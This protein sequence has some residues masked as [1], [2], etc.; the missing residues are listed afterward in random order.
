MESAFE[1]D[2]DTLSQSSVINSQLQENICGSLPKKNE[3][4]A[5]KKPLAATAQSAITCALSLLS[6][7]GTF[8]A[9]WKFAEPTVIHR[10]F[11]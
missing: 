1:R 4:K 2:N 6:L 11:R 8:S 9:G 3:D 5:K 7:S 10:L